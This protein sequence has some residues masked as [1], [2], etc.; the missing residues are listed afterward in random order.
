MNSPGF[1]VMPSGTGRVLDR[2]PGTARRGG[3]ELIAPGCPTK[4]DIVGR[5]PQATPGPDQISTAPASS[6]DLKTR[7][8]G[9][10]G[11]RAG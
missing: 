11:A 10:G 6:A 4:P 1:V 3:C 5:T 7:P 8:W 9:P 2:G